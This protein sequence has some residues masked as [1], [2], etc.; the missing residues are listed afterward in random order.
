MVPTGASPAYG[1]SKP[2]QSTNRRRAEG[3]DAR[4]RPATQ[5]STGVEARGAESLENVGT[6]N[7][8]ASPSFMT[9]L[10][11]EGG[12]NVPFSSIGRGL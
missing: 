12:L 8:R 9:G 10:R 2:S 4:M 1:S 3:T 6:E 5:R 11:S 7:T